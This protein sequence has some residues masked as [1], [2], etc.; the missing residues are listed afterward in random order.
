MLERQHF[1]LGHTKDCFDKLL[2]HRLSFEVEDFGAFTERL[3]NAISAIVAH[4]KNTKKKHLIIDVGDVGQVSI[5]TYLSLLRCSCRC[6]VD[7]VAASSVSS[8]TAVDDK[9][10]IFVQL[11]PAEER[12]VLLVE[13]LMRHVRDAH[14][15]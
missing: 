1:R 5:I 13:C 2:N 12:L 8:R 6:L 9:R 14:R 10:N 4:S 15:G 3:E 7:S 11:E